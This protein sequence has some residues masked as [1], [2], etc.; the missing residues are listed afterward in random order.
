MRWATACLSLTWHNADETWQS[1]EVAH[2]AVFG[3]GHL[4]WEWITPTPIRSS[5][6]PLLFAPVFQLLKVTRMDHFL[7]MELAPR[8]VQ[9]SIT[10]I[11]DYCIINFYK[12]VENIFTFLLRVMTFL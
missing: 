11:G 1:V 7:A 3:Y 2:K 10:A 6:H 8:L 9:G 5:L 12:V 4:T